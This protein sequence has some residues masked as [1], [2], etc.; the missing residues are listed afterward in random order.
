MRRKQIT[1]FLLAALLLTLGVGMLLGQTKTSSAERR[2]LTQ[3]PK[4]TWKAISSGSFTRQ[5]EEAATDQF[6]FRD[7][8]RTVKA[9]SAYHLFGRLD[10]NGYYFSGSSIGKLD[11][12]LSESAVLAICEKIRKIQEN[13]LS[14]TDCRVFYSII[15]DKNQ[16]LSGSFPIL[17]YSKMESLL[18]G[19]LPDMTYIPLLDCLN[20]DSYYATDPHWRQET[21][22][23]VVNRLGAYLDFTPHTAF[24]RREFS[25]YGAYYG[26]AALP[27]PA[28]TLTILESDA[29]RAASVFNLETGQTGGVYDRDKLTSQDPYSVYLSGPAALEVVTNP[30]A[31]TQRKL[32]LFRD[33]FG[34]SLAPLLLDYYQEITL[35]DLRYMPDSVLQ[36][37][38][39]FQN[40]DVLFAYST[41]ILNTSQI[42]R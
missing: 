37:Y 42:F 14:G 11:D 29:T 1:L 36:D 5:A 12:P 2:N 20:A 40:Q 35:V 31:K 8:F 41:L 9:L 39:D 27:L 21:L 23:P 32:V 4:L 18:A 3:W 15:P 33:S 30:N 38:I 22:D 26:Q 28:E 25:F 17:D 13:Y 10:N 7:D 34:S 16:Y 24:D 19:Q 6:P